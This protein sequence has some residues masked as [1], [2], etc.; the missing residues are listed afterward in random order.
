MTS[1][2]ARANGAWLKHDFDAEVRPSGYVLHDPSS[3]ITATY[4]CDEASARS[5]RWNGTRYTPGT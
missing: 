4:G 5:A 1:E 2:T 3:P